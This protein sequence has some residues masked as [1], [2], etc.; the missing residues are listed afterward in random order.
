MTDD[1]FKKKKEEYEARIFELEAQIAKRDTEG[2]STA[3]L[4][5]RVAKMEELLAALAAKK[6]EVKAAPAPAP[7]PEPMPTPKKV[8]NEKPPEKKKGWGEWEF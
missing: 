6:E 4:E 8:P 2:K 5:A 7:T 1:E 3:M